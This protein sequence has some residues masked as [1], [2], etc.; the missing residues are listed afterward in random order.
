MNKRLS[1]IHRKTNE[2]DVYI[3]LNIEGEGNANIKTTIPFLDHM[4]DLFARHGMFD[5][6]VLASGDTE[7]DEHHLIEDMGISFGKL[8]K[9]CLGDNRGINRFGFASLPMDD[10]LVECSLDIS[11]RAY[12]VYNMMDKKFVIADEKEKYE[13]YEHFLKSLAFNAGI[14]LH[15]NLRYGFNLHHNIEAAFKAFGRALKDAVEVTS[16]IMPSTKGCI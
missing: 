2:T 3:K 1:E 7:I 9:R 6:E 12:L 13:L 11:G 10:S 4:L 8:I 16:D 15:F 14:T 5:L